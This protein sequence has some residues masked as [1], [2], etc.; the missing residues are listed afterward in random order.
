VEL[1]PRKGIIAVIGVYILATILFVPGSILTFGTAYA[2][3]SAYHNKVHGVIVASMVSNY[4][5]I[6]WELDCY[7]LPLTFVMPCNCR[8]Y[9]LVLLW[10]HC[11]PFFWDVIF[12]GAV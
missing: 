10:G 11:Q 5:L 6:C 9:S 12:F 2:F 1:H 4:L 3:G 7:I 8:R